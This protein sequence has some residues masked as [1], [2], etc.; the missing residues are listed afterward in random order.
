[1]GAAW[2]VWTAHLSNMPRLIS[3][4]TR[5][6]YPNAKAVLE[7]EIPTV[8]KPVANR[9]IPNERQQKKGRKA[10]RKKYGMERKTMM[11]PSA[12]GK[13]SRNAASAMDASHMKELLSMLVTH[14]NLPRQY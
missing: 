13:K 5:A 7:R 3:D 12:R 9:S 10:R 1:M 2:I 6:A 14:S 8:A 11:S 4:L